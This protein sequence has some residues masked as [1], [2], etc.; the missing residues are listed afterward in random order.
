MLAFIVPTDWPVKVLPL[1]RVRE[2]LQ[3]Q[4]DHITDWQHSI[5]ERLSDLLKS[6]LLLFIEDWINLILRWK[7]SLPR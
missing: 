4:I 1:L 6:R 3:I 7:V 5:H 2:E